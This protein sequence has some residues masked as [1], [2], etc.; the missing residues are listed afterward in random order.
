MEKNTLGSG[1]NPQGK[2]GGLALFYKFSYKVNIVSCNN[3][4]TDVETEYN[5]KQIFIS[6]V[7]GEP[8]QNL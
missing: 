8:N 3:M 2:S 6:F 4:I 1:S 5:G 7:Y